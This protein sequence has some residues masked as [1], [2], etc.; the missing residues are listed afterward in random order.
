MDWLTFWMDHKQLLDT[1][2]EN[3]ANPVNSPDTYRNM[4]DDLAP[5]LVEKI[6]ALK[7]KIGP[8][9]AHIISKRSAQYSDRFY[10]G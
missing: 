5:L 4:I 9:Y 8:D 3:F 1:N 2:P 10:N 6:E 7:K